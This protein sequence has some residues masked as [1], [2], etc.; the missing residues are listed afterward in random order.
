MFYTYRTAQWVAGN[1]FYEGS[2]HMLR[3]WRN[4]QLGVVLI[5]VLAISIAMIIVALSVLNTNVNL[6]LSGQ[7]QIDRIKAE[8]IAKGQFWRNHSSLLTTGVAAAPWNVTLSESHRDQHGVMHTYS[9]NFSASV[10]DQGISSAPGL[11]GARQ[12]DI[13]VP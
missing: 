2:H 10:T 7:R 5:S 11:N 9:K 13:S 8:Q 6:T 4:N 3:K 1:F 12:Y